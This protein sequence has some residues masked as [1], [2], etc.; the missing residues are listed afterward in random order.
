MLAHTV[1]NVSPIKANLL[2]TTNWVTLLC[3]DA[4]RIILC[5][6]FIDHGTKSEDIQKYLEEHNHLS[7]A[8][9]ELVVKSIQK[10]LKSTYDDRWT[11]SYWTKE[12]FLSK[13]TSWLDGEFKLQFEEVSMDSPPTTSGER[14]RP[15]KSYEDIS[16]KSKK[17]KNMVNLITLNV[18]ISREDLLLYGTPHR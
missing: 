1:F 7:F 4:I 14:G 12:R 11:K 13:N 17:R 3:L 9:S 18:K 10:M 16:E 6:F 5:V 2:S 8:K 15:P